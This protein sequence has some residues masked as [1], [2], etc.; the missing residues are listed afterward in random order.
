MPTNT[1]IPAQPTADEARRI[2]T[3]RHYDILDTAPEQAL[4]DLTALAAQICGAPIAL[5]SL[6][7]E[8]RQWFKARVGLEMTET[9]REVSFC[10][11]AVHHR[12]L[13]IVPDATQDERFAGSP[14]VTGEP[15]IRFYAGA[16]LVSPQNSAL[17]DCNSNL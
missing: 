5:I 7:D 10:G 13:F 15:R 16:P 14:L 1:I 12:D 4:D 8:H 2:E 11:H 6:V 9:A 3:L 17:V